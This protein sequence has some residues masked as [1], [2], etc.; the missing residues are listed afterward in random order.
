MSYATSNG[1]ALAGSDYL[2]AGGA[3]QFAPGETT[4]TVSV[5][6]N[7][8]VLFETNELFFV[9]L[10]GPLNAIL[11]RGQAVGTILDDEVR[12]TSVA[13]HSGDLRLE[14]NTLAGRSYRVERTENLAA[15]NIWTTVTNVPAVLDFQNVIT[16]PIIGGEKFFR[17]KKN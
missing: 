14:F 16:N 13:R 7:G 10:S 12:V 2:A 9:N 4:Q 15:T 5:A 6:V 3:L 11:V 1:T 8:D 17:L